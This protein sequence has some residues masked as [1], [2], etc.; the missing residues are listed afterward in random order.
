MTCHVRA[1]GGQDFLVLGLALDG[2]PL[3]H[4]SSPSELST[5]S[6]VILTALQSILFNVIATRRRVHGLLIFAPTV[7]LLGR[8]QVEMWCARHRLRC[9]QLNAM[10]HHRRL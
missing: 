4:P 5:V 2:V 6:V 8:H 10:V 1:I 3:E 9:H 7:C